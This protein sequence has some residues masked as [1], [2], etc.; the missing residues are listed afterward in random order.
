MLTTLK[1]N[2]SIGRVYRLEAGADEVIDTYSTPKPVV[3]STAWS[4]W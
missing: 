1:E 2:I 3:A 4:S